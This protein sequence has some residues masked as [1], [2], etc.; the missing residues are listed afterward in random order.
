[1]YLP[2]WLWP[3]TMASLGGRVLEEAE[4]QGLPVAEVPRKVVR[5]C[6]NGMQN[7]PMQT[8]TPPFTK[9]IDRNL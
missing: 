1:M 2:Q 4:W 3:M 7:K 9:T 5:R 6:Q 8:P